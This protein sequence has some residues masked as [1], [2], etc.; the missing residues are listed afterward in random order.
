VIPKSVAVIGLGLMGGSL[1]LALR[2]AD[3]SIRIAGYD[4]DPAN[5]AEALRRGAATELLET[6]DRLGNDIELAL[7]AVPPRAAPELVDRLASTLSAGATLVDL[8]SVMLP[9]LAAAMRHP[10]LADRYVPA[11][12]LTGSERSGI[13][14]ARGDLY[15]GV[16]ILVGRP[17]DAG[18]AADRVASLWTALGARPRSIAPTLH[19]ALVALTS[20]LPYAASVSLVRTLRRTGSMTR[21]LAEVA[22]PGLRD[23]TRIAGSSASLW[24]EILSLNGPKLIP[25]LELLEREVRALRHAIA[26]GGPALQAHLEEARAFREELSR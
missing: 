21:E 5:A 12:P 11:H 26:E 13:E 6:P 20:H 14:A 9:A 17:L 23:T 4:E 19:D 10:T 16:T 1:G 8:S 3:P 15:L 2:A 22:G 18:S 7:L 24:A 25:A